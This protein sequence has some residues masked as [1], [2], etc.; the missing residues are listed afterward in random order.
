[1][2]LIRKSAGPSGPVTTPTAGLLRVGSPDER[3]AAA[4]SLTTPADVAALGAAL[5]DE[6]EARVREAILTSLAS[7][8]TAE[9]AAVVIP[10]VRSDD[11]NLRTGALDALGAM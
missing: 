10:Y 2:P 9:S 11:A 5:A 7:I 3:W 1:M 8:A 6:R 4:R